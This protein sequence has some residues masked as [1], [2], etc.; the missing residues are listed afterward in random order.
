MLTHSYD[1]SSDLEKGHCGLFPAH[2]PLPSLLNSSAPWELLTSSRPDTDYCQ[3]DPCWACRLLL[4]TTHSCASVPE[5]CI[6][7]QS[8]IDFSAT[9]YRQ[10]C[11]DELAKWVL[12]SHRGTFVKT[13]FKV[14]Y[15]EE[16]DPMKSVGVAHWG[17]GLQS[18]SFLSNMESLEVG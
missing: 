1:P 4:L 5:S 16:L 7:L 12:L 2:C 8:S 18:Q 14:V 10:E 11:Y 13:F 17:T 9:W 15:L 6:Q 3:L